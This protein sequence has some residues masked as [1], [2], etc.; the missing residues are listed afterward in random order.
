MI[1]LSRITGP[2]L[3]G[4]LGLYLDREGHE[5]AAAPCVPDSYPVPRLQH[6]EPDSLAVERDLAAH[7]HV[8]GQ[9]VA[10]DEYR[11]LAVDGIDTV[12][13]TDAL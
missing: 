2:A 5:E 7:G 1:E 8:K 9:E 3:K 6:A 11:Q 13:D 4:A 10:V 12:D